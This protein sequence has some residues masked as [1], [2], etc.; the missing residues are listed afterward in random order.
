MNLGISSTFSPLFFTTLIVIV[1]VLISF[2]FCVD[3]Q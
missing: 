3:V 1:I 2:S